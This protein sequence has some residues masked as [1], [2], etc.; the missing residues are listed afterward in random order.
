MQ[1]EL[2]NLVTRIGLRLHRTMSDASRSGTQDLL[3]H[4]GLVY[5][6]ACGRMV[7]MRT[8]TFQLNATQILNAGLQDR[9]AR[10]RLRKKLKERKVVV[11]SVGDDEWV[12]F[13]DG[14]WLCQ[15][16]RL[17]KELKSLILYPSR[18]LSG[19]DDPRLPPLQNGSG[20]RDLERCAGLHCNDVVIMHRPAKRMINATH[21]LKAGGIPFYSRELRRF[22]KENNHIAT[23]ISRGNNAEQGTYISYDNV[24]ALC[25]QFNLDLPPVQELIGQAEDFAERDDAHG[26]ANDPATRI[27]QNGPGAVIVKGFDN[28]SKRIC[29]SEA[30]H[31]DIPSDPTT[32]IKQTNTGAVSVGSF[33]SCSNSLSELE[34]DDSDNSMASH[35]YFTK[36]K[37]PKGSY[38]APANRSY[39]QMLDAAPRFKP[40][41]SIGTDEELRMEI[42]NAR[43]EWA[44]FW[45]DPACEDRTSGISTNNV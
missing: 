40:T 22:L 5:M 29:A 7:S 38:L 37:F 34:S 3:F 32:R 4:P 33:N 8:S 16:V 27:E 24:P 17:D 25:I 42:E 1:G 35:G 6:V 44:G 21:I 45:E 36:P 12:P 10:Y 39:K 43:G 28:P 2:N 19:R 20:Y 15:Q 31:R 23:E 13:P 11:E 18:T 30:D 14:L 9:H 41:P 26:I